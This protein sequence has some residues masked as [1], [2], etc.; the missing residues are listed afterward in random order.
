MDFIKGGLG[1]QSHEDGFFESTFRIIVIVV[2]IVL[3]Y[4]LWSQLMGDALERRV[5]PF[6]SNN[7]LATFTYSAGKL[8]KS[9][10]H[11]EELSH[12][13]PIMHSQR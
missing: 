3:L 8:K 5:I 2:K 6:C 10:L 4:F 11:S 1:S 13:A 9:G 7:G 12:F